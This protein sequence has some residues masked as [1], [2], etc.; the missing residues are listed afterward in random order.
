MASSNGGRGLEK[1]QGSLR[2]THK[3]ALE[4]R[5]RLKALKNGRGGCV[6]FEFKMGEV[7]LF[8]CVCG[9]SDGGRPRRGWAVTPGKVAGTQKSSGGDG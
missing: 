4:V 1:A 2:D 8:R 7:V 5:D 9:W 6:V 3:D